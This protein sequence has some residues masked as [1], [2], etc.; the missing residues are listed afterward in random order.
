VIHAAGAPAIRGGCGQQKGTTERPSTPV[1]PSGRL[2]H[3][4]RRPPESELSVDELPLV[5]IVMPCMNEER[6]IEACLDCLFAQDYPANKIE[7]LV[8]DG[9][10]TDG[11]R[12]ILQRAKGK[13][14]RVRIV[15]N[16]QRLQAAGLNQAIRQARGEVII[17]MD[18]HAEYA[19]D[20]VRQCVLVLEETGADNVGGAARPRAKTFFQR[21]LAAALESPLGIGNSKFRQ[22]DAEGF[23]D[24]VFPGAFRRR[25]FESVGLFDSKAITNEDAEFNQ[26]IHDAGGKVYLSR[27]IVVHYYPRESMGA[28]FKQYFRYGKGR[29]R[30]LLKHGTFLT[31]RPALPFALVVGGAALLLTSRW[32]SLSRWAFGGYALATLAEAVR[33]GRK[34][35][36]S[37]IPVVWAIF[38]VL[39]VAHGTGFAA[40]LVHYALHPDWQDVERLTVDDVSVDGHRYQQ[41]MEQRI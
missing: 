18:V 3:P 26:R 27:R 13:D 5:T 19:P 15:D 14:G 30:T 22:A 4:N 24:T 37:S 16:P 25:V 28:L 33:V 38:P 8:A 34:A 6:Y 29:A 40:G 11:T 9:M 10:S 41:V 20:F 2:R 21:A 12:S 17:R 39:H 31:V 1:S 35:S 7:I 36:L 32:H 23:V